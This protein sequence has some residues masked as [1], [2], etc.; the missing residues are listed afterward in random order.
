MKYIFS[1]SK[2]WFKVTLDQLVQR[3][4]KGVATGGVIYVEKVNRTLD[5]DI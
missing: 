2:D 1:F 3:H 4:K 5:F